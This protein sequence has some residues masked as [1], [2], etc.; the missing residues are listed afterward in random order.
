MPPDFA[1]A[2]RRFEAAIAVPELPI[3]SIRDRSRKRRAQRRSHLVVACTLAALAL[4]ASG[5]VLAARTSGMRIWLSGNHATG[6]ITSFASITNP[7]PEDLRRIVGDAT[8]P[9][10]L[11]LGM[12]PGLHLKLLVFSPTDHPNVVMVQY[13]NK[14]G[15]TW[16]WILADS[17]VVE[18][19]GFLRFRTAPSRRWQS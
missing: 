14:T 9:V 1:E 2:G 3:A 16:N 5:S 10:V 13:E 18:H 6:T 8:F 11:P 7:T 12:P 19:G 4:L 15:G 17:S